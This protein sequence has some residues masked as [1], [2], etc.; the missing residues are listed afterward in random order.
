MLRRALIIDGLWCTLCP[1]FG[2]LA[3]TRPALESRPG[4]QSSRPRSLPATS[5][6]APSRRCYSAGTS[7]AR[8]DD[9]TKRETATKNRQ[10]VST[11][12]IESH[13]LRDEHKHFHD[14]RRNNLS[15]H[16]IELWAPELRTKTIRVYKDLVEK[17]ISYLEGLLQRDKITTNIYAIT[18]VLRA[19]IRDHHVEPSARH[20]KALILAHRDSQRGSPD[21]VRG[22]LEEMEENGITADSGTL[23]ATL[24]VR[25]AH[26]RMVFQDIIL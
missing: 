1:S 23:H 24:Q 5:A 21:A 4:K 6:S 10:N 11:S 15:K 7:R 20:Y 18:Q 3:I 25:I 16:E 14:P 13:A 19:L 12:D 26:K 17:P 22:L 8:K 9:N 2:Q